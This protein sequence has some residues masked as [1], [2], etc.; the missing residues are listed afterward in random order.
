MAGCDAANRERHAAE[1]S[2]AAEKKRRAERTEAKQKERK[3]EDARE[4]WRGGERK[5]KGTVLRR[6]EKERASRM[7]KATTDRERR[8]QNTSIAPLRRGLLGGGLGGFIVT[9]PAGDNFLPKNLKI[10]GNFCC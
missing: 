1:R 10:L 7:T 9:G 8:G 6:K 4:G 5:K 3:K 2:D